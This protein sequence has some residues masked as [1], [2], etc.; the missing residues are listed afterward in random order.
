MKVL[1]KSK[2]LDL[3]FVHIRRE[4]G[5]NDLVSRLRRRV[6]RG[7]HFGSCSILGSSTHG[8]ISRGT[9]HLGFGSTTAADSTQVLGA[10]GNNLNELSHRKKKSYE[11][12]LLTSSRDLSIFQ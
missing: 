10:G 5:N 8:C 2:Y 12:I 11:R 4:I 3:D 6:G 9:Q 7:D 1:G